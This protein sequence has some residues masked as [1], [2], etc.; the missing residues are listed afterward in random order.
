[1]FNCDMLCF[2]HKW[3]SIVLLPPT[4]EPVPSP[5]IL[6]KSP[7][8]TPDWCKVTLECRASRATEDLNVTWENKGLPKEWKQR[9]T[10]GLASNTCTLTVSL[11]LSHPHASLICVVS[12]QVDKK[13]ISL[14]LGK[15]CASGE[16]N[17]PE[18]RSTFRA[19]ISLRS[20]GSELHSPSCY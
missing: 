16:C 10:L 8:I 9:R 20:G 17:L 5:Q 3:S 11:P 18:G 14:E 15:F 13:T 12:N 6:M 2:P 7:S 19:Q 1:M 4:P